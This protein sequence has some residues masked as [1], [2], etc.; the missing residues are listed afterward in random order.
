MCWQLKAKGSY[1]FNSSIN[2]QLPAVTGD[3]FRRRQQHIHVQLCRKVCTWPKLSGSSP[4]KA[5]ATSQAVSSLMPACCLRISSPQ[6]SPRFVDF[7][8]FFG[9]NGYKLRYRESLYDGISVDVTGLR[10]YNKESTKIVKVC[11]INY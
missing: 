7:S 1:S 11:S 10:F 4:S 9:Y 3:R 6:S 5:S 8:F 2:P